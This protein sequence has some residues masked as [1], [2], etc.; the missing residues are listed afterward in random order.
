MRGMK[1]KVS[2]S[3]FWMAS[4]LVLVL[5]PAAAVAGHQPN[6]LPVFG[7]DNTRHELLYSAEGIR[8]E[9]HLYEQTGRFRYATLSTSDGGKCARGDLQF[10]RTGDVIATWTA[11]RACDTRRKVLV[12]K[13]KRRFSRDESKPVCEQ[14]EHTF[15]R[16]G[17][18]LTLKNNCD[19]TITLSSGDRKMVLSRTGR[20]KYRAT[21]DG[22]RVFWLR[23]KPGATR[24][25]LSARIRRTRVK[26]RWQLR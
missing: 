26:G 5:T 10:V 17:G 4:S 18:T 2:L 21:G 7:A 15:E 22:W 11:W 12:S 3:W 13:V 6:P 25:S 24:M 1:P 14:T 19:G 8:F 20:G 23:W 9:G 16:R